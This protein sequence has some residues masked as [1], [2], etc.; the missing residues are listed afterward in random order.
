MRE[1]VENSRRHAGQQPPA[2]PD[3]PRW[4]TLL[5]PYR[6][7]ILGR[8][9]AEFVVTVVPFPCYRLGE[10]LREHPELQGVSRLTL[11]ESFRCLS[12]ALWDED[13]RRLVG[14]LEARASL[15]SGPRNDQVRASSS[16]SLGAAG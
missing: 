8:S 12:L 7:P 14:F 1:T 13:K 15:V 11:K 9:L 10:V 3:A 5:A 16:A 4:V 6:Q 2:E